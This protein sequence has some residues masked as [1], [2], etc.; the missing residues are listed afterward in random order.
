MKRSTFMKPVAYSLLL[1]CGLVAKTVA[2]IKPNGSTAPSS[3]TPITAPGAYSSGILINYLRTREAIA[4]ITSAVV[5]DGADPTQARQTTQYL[6]GLGRPIQTVI[7]QFT[8]GLKDLVSPMVYDEFGREA[9]KYL[10]YADTATSGLFK[11]NPFASQA[12]FMSSFY[13]GE[14]VYY[15]QSLFEPSPLNRVS[16]AMSPGNSW[17]D[18][19]RSIRM[20]YLVNDSY[21]SVR[22]WNIGNDTLTYSNNDSLT[23]IPTSSSTYGA[24]QL[25]ET[26]TMDEHGNQVVEYKDKEG[27]VIL[28]K[29]QVASS[30]SEGH[31]GWLCTYYVYD[32]YG[33]LRFVIPP[34]AVSQLA[35][36]SWD[37]TNTGGILIKELC[38]RY[39]YDARQR[40]IA[41]KVPGAGWAYDVYDRRDRLGFTQDANMRNANQWMATVYDD[42]N[43]TASTGMISYSGNRSSLQ[44]LLDNHFD[45]ASTTTISLNFSAPDKLYVDT[46]ESGKTAYHAVT[47]INFTGEFTTESGAEAETI[48]G[49]ATVSTTSVLLNYD[50]FP[51]S[52]NFIPL[53]ATYYDDYTSTSKTYSTA[54]NSSLND[55]GNANPEALP[56]STSLL[57][58]GMVTGSKVR[59]IENPSDLTVGS[60]METANF[61]DDKGRTIQ[62]QTDNYKSG[63]DIITTRYDFTNRAITN[64]VV[65]HNAAAALTLKTKTNFLYDPQGRLL[66]VKK[67][68]NDDAATTRYLAINTYDELGQLLQKQVG[69]KSSSDTTAMETLDKTYNIRGWLQGINE[70]YSRGTGTRWFGMELNYDWGFTGSQ[71]NGNIAGI[72]WRSR[73]DGEQRAYGFG[74]DASNRLLKG[75]FTQYTSSTWGNNAGVDFSMK[76]GD[77]TNYASAYDEN[78]NIKA[79]WQK[80]LKLGSSPTI[81]SLS[82]NYT[83]NTNKLLNVIDGANDTT[84]KMGDFRSSKRYMDAIGSKSSSATDY[85]YDLN[86]NL[87]KDLNKDIGNSGTS[88]ISYNHLNLPY[89]VWVNGKG[90]ITYIYDAAGNKLEKRTIDST[91]SPVKTTTTTYLNGY[92]YQNDS[93]QFFAQEEGRIR[94]KDTAFVYDYF[95]KDHLGNVRVVLTDEVRQDPYPAVTLEDGTEA[96]DSLYYA[97]NPANIASNPVYIPSTYPNNNGNPPYNPDPSSSTASTSTKMYKLSGTGGDKTGL[98]ITLKVMS[99]DV[100]NIWAKSF[101]HST[102]S[103]PS[104]PYA[105]V[106]NDLLTSLAGTSSVVNSGK[107]I[108]SSYLIGSST[109]PTQVSHWISDSIPTI[110]GVPRAYINWLLFDNQFN[111]VSSSSGFDAVSSTY[112]DL[113]SHS[114]TVDISKN[115]YLYVYCSNESD[116]PVFFDNLQLIHT[117]GPLLEETHYYPFGLTMN[118]ISSK[119]AGSLT[120]RYK[121]NGK[122]LQSQEFSDG[123][124]FELYDYGARMQ[125]PQIGRWL[126][127]D[128]LAGKYGSFSPY[129]YTANEPIKFIDPDGRDI[130]IGNMS[131]EDRTRILNFLQQLT[132]DRLKYNEKTHQVDIAKKVNAKDNK[133]KSGTDLIRGLIENKLTATIDYYKN[134]VQSGTNPT[135]ETNAENGVGSDVKVGLAGVNMKTQV[136]KGGKTVVE[137]QPFYLVLAQE[138]THS[139]ITMDG[140]DV[141]SRINGANTYLRTDGQ[142]RVEIVEMG[143]LQAHGIGG[144]AP[145]ATPKRNVYPTENSI[146]K[147]HGLPPRVAYEAAYM[148][149]TTK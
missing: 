34:K 100:V 36:N 146:R 124:G 79:M 54:N 90:T 62:T 143:E 61:Y 122:E 126:G 145:P 103:T 102:G 138:L 4:P 52:A 45:A 132:G 123:S 33:L 56:S 16:K 105:I 113:K 87:Q 6:D 64:Y 35:A 97:I 120:N 136:S 3:A 134:K 118:G 41:K 13:S 5:F 74:Y 68:I 63:T 88:G 92:V 111:L 78:G 139:L 101:W 47:E 147:E 37:L 96:T 115:G 110:S 86:G 49:A 57:T 17:S 117:H 109:I 55:G 53:T 26:H 30:P 9:L 116:Q 85:T 22:I 128:P 42:Q 11:L 127:I 51:S 121:Y 20:Q 24:G 99:G 80:G 73:G 107:G 23:N 93:L 2:Q 7:K 32:D 39:E 76:M 129:C 84:T 31:T 25:F 67:T 48:L 98:G 106:V 95:I 14:S 108:T 91:F 27:K 133:L 72:Q 12:S 40:V 69:Q 135:N 38:F 29:V 46:R 58:R 70:S 75:D 1:I 148:S 59:V 44:H 144:N 83:A 15:S 89:Q 149:G 18:T 125:D 130:E 65:H 141:P 50:P 71:Y 119:A 8:P 104:N 66:N 131:K 21:D 114:K 19:S 81:D 140:Y 142:G 77:G 82:Y 137:D 94:K 43:R 28:K 10:P 112:D 60:W